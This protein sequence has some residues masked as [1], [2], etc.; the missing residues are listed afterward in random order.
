[1]TSNYRRNAVMNVG[2][3]F[4]RSPGR[5][6]PRSG[7]SKKSWLTLAPLIGCRK[8]TNV[9]DLPDPRECGIPWDVVFARLINRHLGWFRRGWCDSGRWE[10]CSARGNRDCDTFVCR[11]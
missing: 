11:S 10:M 2:A 5:R 9:P 1:M 7:L 6:R 4:Q 3:G 8:Q